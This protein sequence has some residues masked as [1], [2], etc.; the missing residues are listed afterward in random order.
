MA[1]QRSI[2]L[3]LIDCC[4]MLISCYRYSYHENRF[5]SNKY[6]GYNMTVVWGIRENLF[7]GVQGME[8]ERRDNQKP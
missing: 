2:D 6:V 8:Y 5:T 1:I 4:T 3:I 7:M